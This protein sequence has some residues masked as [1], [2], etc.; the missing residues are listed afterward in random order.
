MLLASTPKFS[1]RFYVVWFFHT[2]F[3]VNSFFVYILKIAPLYSL[4]W[5]LCDLSPWWHGLL[6]V[7]HVIWKIKINVFS[8]YFCMSS[9][10]ISLGKNCICLFL[11]HHDLYI[12]RH[13]VLILVTWKLI[14]IVEILSVSY[15]KWCFSFAYPR[16]MLHNLSFSGTSGFISGEFLSWGFLSCKLGHK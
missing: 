12:R 16:V 1:Y 3:H 6:G 14:E 9:L 15:L 2:F 13:I 7:F 11:S 5:K 8:F 10:D 4:A